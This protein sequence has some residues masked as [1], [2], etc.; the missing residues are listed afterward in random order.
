MTPFTHGIVDCMGFEIVKSLPWDLPGGEID[1]REDR[2]QASERSNWGISICKWPDSTSSGDKSE[3]DRLYGL[4]GPI[5]N[6]RIQETCLGIPLQ[7]ALDPQSAL[8]HFALACGLSIIGKA[9]LELGDAI[10]VAGVNPLALNVLVAARQQCARTACLVPGSEAEAAYRQDIEKLADEM[11]EFE[12]VSSCDAKLHTLIASSRGKTVYV[13]AIGQPSLVYAMAMRL[14]TFGTL[15]LCRQEVTTSVVL[16]LR[17][18]HHLKSAHYIY[19][20]R[21]E[22]LE[23]ALTFSEC[24]RRAASLFQWKRVS[25]L[26]PDDL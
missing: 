5:Q 3:V 7:G 22:T 23:E 19:W 15:V 1:D 6:N 17:E 13:D 21:P 9:K 2:Y 20:A 26:M 11:I 8:S 16:N 24:C 4:I 18:V 25:M 14:E 10:V 12:D